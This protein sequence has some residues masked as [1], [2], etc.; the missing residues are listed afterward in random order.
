MS[1]IEIGAVPAHMSLILISFYT[2]TLKR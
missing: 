1:D 2:K